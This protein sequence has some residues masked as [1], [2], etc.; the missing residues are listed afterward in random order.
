MANTFIVAISIRK[1]EFFD[2]EI[3]EIFFLK[4]PI[5]HKIDEKHYEHSDIHLLSDFVTQT[6]LNK[7]YQYCAKIKPGVAIRHVL[8]NWA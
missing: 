4:N 8:N 7:I 2:E 3:H 6:E 1:I 5:K